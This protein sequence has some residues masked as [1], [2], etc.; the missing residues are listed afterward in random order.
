LIS[1]YLFFHSDSICSITFLVSAI[2]FVGGKKCATYPLL[3]IKNLAKFHG[4]TPASPVFE[5]YKELLFLK[6]TYKGSVLSPLTSIFENIG[7]LAL[8]F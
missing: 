5:L 1:H 7:N 8:K 6:Y 3:F 4:M 2:S